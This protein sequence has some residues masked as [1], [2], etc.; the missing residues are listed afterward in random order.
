[1]TVTPAACTPCP[2]GRGISPASS[3]G[4]SW[5]GLADLPGLQATA[6]EE[7]RGA[8]RSGEE[9]SAVLLE[10]F[11]KNHRLRPSCTCWMENSGVPFFGAGWWCIAELVSACTSVFV[12]RICCAILRYFSYTLW[13]RAV[14][15]CGI[16][17]PEMHN[18][19]TAQTLSDGSN[20]RRHFK[21]KIPSRK[22]YRTHWLQGTVSLKVRQTLS[23]VFRQKSHVGMNE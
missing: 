13:S 12:A 5:R 14:V 2:E 4:L 11:K 6:S 17:P 1:M 21:H 10:V 23:Q 16:C 9:R 20:C 22:Q 15:G 19:N 3:R 18:V 7:Q 8:E